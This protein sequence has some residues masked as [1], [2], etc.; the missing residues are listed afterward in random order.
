M[1]VELFIERQ[2]KW[3]VDSL[4]YLM[5]LYE[6]F[7]HTTDEGRKRG[8]ANGLLRSSKGATKAGP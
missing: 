3:G 8:G 4:L 5:M 6:M 1:D 7:H 2:A